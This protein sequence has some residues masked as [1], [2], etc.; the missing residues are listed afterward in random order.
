M[1]ENGED[2]L[3]VLG[4]ERDEIAAARDRLQEH[5]RRVVRSVAGEHRGKL[6]RLLP[7]DAY[8]CDDRHGANG[9]AG[10]TASRHPKDEE[11]RAMG[12]EPTTLSL[13]S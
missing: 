4:P 6:E 8:A 5:A 3:T 9:I 11:K 10:R 7:R 1:V 2:R 13:G 12:L